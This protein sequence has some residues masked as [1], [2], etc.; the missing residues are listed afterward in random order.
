MGVYFSRIVDNCSCPL[1]HHL[2]AL[3]KDIEQMYWQAKGY[4]GGDWGSVER[5][6]GSRGEVFFLPYFSDGSMLIKLCFQ[7]VHALL[8]LSGFPDGVHFP[9]RFRS[10]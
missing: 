10:D 8:T 4:W 7:S 9:P 1:K 3:S 6:G 5:G 2:C